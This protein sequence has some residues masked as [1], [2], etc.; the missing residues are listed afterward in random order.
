[1]IIIMFGNAQSAVI[2]T[3]FLLILYMNQK[4]NIGIPKTKS[5]A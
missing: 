5:F 2:K 4:K 1:M 3:A